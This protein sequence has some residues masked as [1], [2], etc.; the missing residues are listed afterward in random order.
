ARSDLQ[1]RWHAGGVRR[2]GRLGARA[3]V[4]AAHAFANRGSKANCDTYHRVYQPSIHGI[5][6]R[7]ALLTANTIVRHSTSHPEALNMISRRVP[8]TLR[9]FQ[10]IQ[11]V[12][13]QAQPTMVMKDRSIR[14]CQ[15]T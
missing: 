3:Q 11:A 5:G 8:L 7:N 6:I 4:I 9:Q 12:T 13:T 1:A 2:P 15:P 14:T 10:R